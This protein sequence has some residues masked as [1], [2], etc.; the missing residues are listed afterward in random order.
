[1]TYPE[2]PLSAD[3][4]LN[5][6][7]VEGRSFSAWQKRPVDKDVLDRAYRLAALGPTSMN[8]Q[9]ARFLWLTSE[10]ARARLLA[11]LAPPNVEKTRTAPV[12]IVVAA[13]LAFYDELPRLFPHR[14][15]VRELYASK[16][17]LARETARR[18]CALT[19]GYFI[20]ALRALGL[21]CGP[22]SGFDAAAVDVGFFPDGR[23]K[24]EMVLNVGYG[25]RESL[26]PR[27]PRLGW[28]EAWRLV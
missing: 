20:C 27:L 7:F 4:L 3:E 8:C 22:M 21:D 10:E 18:N 13:D 25:E 2:T 28:E 19:A 5:R 26:F 15:G 24:S 16:P 11:W 12:T 9:P 17:E 6:I 1:V 14:P 23:W